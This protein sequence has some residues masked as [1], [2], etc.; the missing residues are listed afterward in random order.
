MPQILSRWLF[1]AA[2]FLA[3]A[4]P[5]RSELALYMIEQRGCAYC[6]LWDQQVSEAYANSEEGQRAP[7]RRLDLRAPVPENTRFVSRPIFT[8]TFILVQDGQEIGRIEGY[9]A[10]HFFWEHL[11]QLLERVPA[12]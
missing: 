1:V 8:P 4:L 6:K 7:L 9:L 12:P 2:L 10:D 11:T 3:S 5:A